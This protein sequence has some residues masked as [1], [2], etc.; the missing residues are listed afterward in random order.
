[1][2]CNGSHARLRIWCPKGRGGS[3]PLIRTME[4]LRKLIAAKLEQ[5]LDERNKSTTCH[6]FEQHNGMIIAYDDVVKVI[7]TVLKRR[8]GETGSTR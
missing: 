2:W 7:D 6:A 4:E 3:S 5:S 8:C 1:M